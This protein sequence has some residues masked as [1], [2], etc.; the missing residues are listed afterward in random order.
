MSPVLLFGFIASV[1]SLLVSS[2]G[3]FS[4]VITNFKNKSCGMDKV[5]MV[6]IFC[7]YTSWVIYSVV[8]KD[9]F[10]L[11]P[12][13]FGMFLALVMIGQYLKFRPKQVT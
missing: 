10:I 2:V 5:Y 8:K 1:S 13:F 11:I 7:S 4:Q 9:V 6:L 12:H 3:I